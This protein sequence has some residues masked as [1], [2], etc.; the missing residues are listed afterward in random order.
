MPD[1]ILIIENRFLESSIL[2]AFINDH[3]NF[4]TI[5]RLI[6]KSAII[7]YRDGVTRK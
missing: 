2:E 3:I 4:V 6:I 1:N 5:L 7:E